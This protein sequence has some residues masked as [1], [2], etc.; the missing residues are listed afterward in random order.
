M[1]RLVWFVTSFSIAVRA[2]LGEGSSSL[3]PQQRS[4]DAEVPE[5]SNDRPVFGVDG[6]EQD[7]SAVQG[8]GVML[9]ECDRV[10]ERRLERSVRSVRSA[11]LA[12]VGE[13]SSDGV[14]VAGDPDR[15]QSL[16]VLSRDRCSEVSFVDAE[17]AKHVGGDAIEIERREE[18]VLGTGLIDSVGAGDAFRFGQKRVHRGEIGAGTA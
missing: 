8:C 16:F 6:G 4:V 2:R 12:I 13:G 11:R 1:R 18:E 15:S 10:L 17:R 9:R 3:F 5:R 7:V 14:V